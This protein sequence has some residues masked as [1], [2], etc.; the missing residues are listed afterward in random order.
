MW[1]YSLYDFFLLLAQRDLGTQYH[2]Y[3]GSNMSERQIF[4]QLPTKYIPKSR[5]SHHVH[6]E[7]IWILVFPEVLQNQH[8]EN[9]GVWSIIFKMTFE[10]NL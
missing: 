8:K 6:D 1:V 2:R 5:T 4:F 9:G 3:F 7:Y 10:L